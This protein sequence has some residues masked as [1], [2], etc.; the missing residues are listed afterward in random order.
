MT[1]L[2]VTGASGFIGSH[3]IKRCLKDGYL[4]R[5]LVRKGNSSMIRLKRDGVEVIAGDIRDTDA[6]NKAVNGCDIVFHAAALTSDWGALQDFTDINVGGT[7]HVCEAVVRHKV[8]RLVY[9]SSFECFNHSRFERIDEQT[10]YAI[11]NQP[12]ADT[13]IQGSQTVLEY[14]ARGMSATIVY[15]VWVYGPEDRT[16]FP[17]LADG[18]RRRQLFYWSRNAQMNMIYIDN[19]VDLLMH[20]ALHP[21]AAGESFLACD[22]KKCTFEELCQR[23]ADG[24]HSPPP[25]RYLPYTF[26]YRLAGAMELIYRIIRSSKRPLLTRQ[27]VILLASHT[28]VDASKARRVLGWSPVVSQ[29]EG[30]R[31]TLKWLITIDPSEWKQ[32]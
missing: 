3:L 20:A 21:E 18:I 5:A 11:R 17:L 28:V 14:A 4:V 25:S 32:K 24:I 15:P 8:Q 19:L 2:L 7:R 9:I 29:D 10:P 26:V 1:V 6:V 22:G 23:V 30:I 27:A 13:K 12:Y 16:L 31:R